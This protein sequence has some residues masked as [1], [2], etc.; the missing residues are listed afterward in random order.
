[1]TPKQAW[2]LAL[3][4]LA[5][6]MMAL[7]SLVVT[8]AL[9][10]IR[11]DLT[12]SL[13]ALEWTV[14]AY[15]LTFA[16]LLLTGA[17]LGD[18]FGRRR[19]FVGGLAVFT[20]ASVA[21]ALSPNIGSLIA[22]RAL[23]GVGAAMVLPLSLTLISA[24]FPPRQRGKA[25]GLYLGITGLAT[26]GG[27]FVG[28][29]IAEG[30]AWQWIFWL[31][32]PLG[33]IV[34]MLT[35]RRV[36]ESV[37]P[38]NRFDLGGVV[39]V[40]LGA[41]G[42]V[43]GLVRGNAAGWSSAEVLGALVLGVALVVAFVL[44]E[45]RTK[46]PMLPMRFFRVRAF[47]TANPA[48]FTVFAS[49]YGTLFF[50][51][52]YFQTVHGEGPLG[53]G[54]RLMPWTATLMV[55]APIAGALADRYGERVFVVGGLLLQTIGTGWLAMV[56]DTDTGY[57][58]LLPALIIGGIGLTMA[59]PAAQKSVVGAVQPQEIGQ[60][61][62]AFMMLRIFGGVFGVA[63]AVAVFASVGGY[64]SPE[65][66]SE[67]FAAAMGAVSALAFIGMLVALG[68][69]AK[70]PAAMPTPPQPT[71]AAIRNTASAETTGR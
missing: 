4:S 37:G 15:N 61:S 43:W 9:S 67:G 30:L 17:A 31:N 52:Q 56:A 19:M 39:L 68:I 60:A 54:L 27:P 47:A 1:M 58:E 28:G 66:F 45:Q 3:A 7:D 38:N 41:F 40:T 65:E 51:A 21:C 18:R 36:D 55:C 32:L 24:M 34:I 11:Q 57:L 62:G 59:M 71:G 44:W 53:A 12:A 33:L 13:E 50:L 64:A 42:I 6:F 48:N 25:M 8:T 20:V 49:L 70:R 10:T 46:A 26:F 35:A 69:P 5:S 63:V 22:S 2:V 14:N 16:V 23:Q 29:V